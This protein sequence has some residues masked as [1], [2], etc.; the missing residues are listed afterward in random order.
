VVVIGGDY[1]IGAN[2]DKLIYVFDKN[3]GKKKFILKGHL[4]K[5]STLAISADGQFLA[6]AGEDRNII[7]WNLRY[8]TFSKVLKGIGTRINTIAFSNDGHELFIGYNDGLFRLWNLREEGGIISNSAPSFNFYKGT[9]DWQYSITDC[10]DSFREQIFM[11]ASLN[12]RNKETKRE[13]TQRDDL[14]VWEPHA[15]EG[16]TSYERYK[17]SK[18]SRQSSF[19]LTETSINRFR[20]SATYPQRKSLFN[21]FKF[22]SPPS[23]VLHVDFTRNELD[24]DPALLKRKKKIRVKGDVIHQSVSQSGTYLAALIFEGQGQNHCDVRDGETGA[25][26]FSFPIEDAADRVGFSPDER[27]LYV[28]SN[29]LQFTDFWD[30]AAHRKQFTTSAVG[31][32]GFSAQTPTIAF[33][34]AE[35]ALVIIDGNTGNER[36]RTATGHTA[37]ISDIQFNDRHGFLGTAS[38]DGCIRCWDVNDGSLKVSLA[39]FNDHDFIFIDPDNYYHA[40]LGA[41]G[42]VAFTIDDR[43][44]AFEQFDMVYNRPDKVMARL[45]FTSKSLLDTY[46]LAY[47]KRLK[48][49]GMKEEDLGLAHH[50]PELSIDM[51]TEFQIET[52][53]RQLIVNYT[54]S[55][56][57]NPLIRV[58]VWLN[59]VPYYG[60]NG[61]NIQRMNTGYYRDSVQ[62]SLSPGL[63]KVQISCINED[64]AESIKETF[65]ISYKRKGKEKPDLYLVA[66]GV[67]HYQDTTKNLHYAAK[68]ARDLATLYGRKTDVYHHIT[69]DSL[70]DE[71]VTTENLL[72]IK[73]HL[74]QSDIDDEVILFFAG[75]GVLSKAYDYYLG[76]Y[77]MD[78][79]RPETGLLYE[80]FISLIDS[81]PARKKLVLMDAC[82]SGEIDKEEVK[83]AEQSSM[84]QGKKRFRTAGGISIAS[85]NNTFE[86][87]KSVFPDFRRGSGAHIISS[88]GATEYAQESDEWENGIFTLCLMEGLK[89]AKA[90]QNKDGE[91]DVGEI[92]DY[93]RTNVYERTEGQQLPTSRA[94]NYANN[95]TIWKEKKLNL[96]SKLFN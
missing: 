27:L 15:P 86:V 87:L 41:I 56:S 4:Q 11:K 7:L 77:D 57:L 52:T 5:I 59:D 60:R 44:Y 89:D 63:N 17:N 50:I 28:Q 88:A 25:V 78:F 2:N 22:R 45:G 68:D 74:M 53:E 13:L 31:P 83:L 26:L 94:V 96:W 82:H 6:S 54:A 14:I 33:A 46:H 23:N 95:Y 34:N 91:V 40:S 43:L 79:N 18:S 69:I 75:H 16:A 64:G 37:P 42:N 71:E 80:T 9:N 47:K 20:F 8:G 10:N 39:A 85:A 76:T 93:L 49:L 29:A 73:P 38:Y 32:I 90:D 92:Q 58:N 67:S 1:F 19:T 65:E 84:R 35:R 55:D 36:F 81:I 51:G 3:N 12:L 48:L 30:L 62:L 24:E 66:L 21:S 72:A 61:L 70:F